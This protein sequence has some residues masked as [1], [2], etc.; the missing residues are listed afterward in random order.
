MMLVLAAFTKLK[1]PKT[2]EYI[3]ASST[4]MALLLTMGTG[5]FLVGLCMLPSV[6]GFS[7]VS[8]GLVLMIFLLRKLLSKGSLTFRRGM[9]AILATRGLFFAAYT[10]IQLNR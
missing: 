9:P 7:L 10:S 4:W 2:H 8:I 6:M 1:T 5:I 3:G